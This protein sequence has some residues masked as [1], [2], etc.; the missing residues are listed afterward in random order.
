MKR[1]VKI[2]LNDKVYG[3]RVYE[4]QIVEALKDNVVFDRIFL[5][6]Y[7]SKLLNI[8]RILW[9][10]LKY[11]FFFKGTLLLTNPTTFF[12]GRRS[13]NIVIIHHIEDCLT[14]RPADIFQR[15]CDRYFFKH[16]R[17]YHVVVTVSEVWKKQFE[18]FGFKNIRVIYNSFDL[19]D[20]IF[21]IEEIQQFKEQN[22]LSGS[23]LVYIGNCQLKK[24][25]KEAYEVLRNE[26]YIL[27]TSG[28]KQIDIPV[29]N[30][31][32]SFREYKILL[33]AS[34]V[35]LTMSKFTE[36]WNRTAHEAS[37]CG[38]PVVGTGTGGMHE[39]LEI[40]NQTEL[41]DFKQLPTVIKERLSKEY[42]PTPKLLS[43][44][45]TYFKEQWA[46]VFNSI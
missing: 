24:G 28:E 40:A 39:L 41:K 34:D 11:K 12:A 18:E 45:N 19:K 17:R 38:T 5:M 35:V 27:V 29:K 42:V 46:S 20:Y 21:P 36:G 44:N 13:K 3:G 1:I 32:L 7:K 6:K 15:C 16:S 23:P 10:F 30:L 8:P 25:V 22:K 43:L 31:N 4:N 33:A 14:N 26:G 2:D 37:L 9:L